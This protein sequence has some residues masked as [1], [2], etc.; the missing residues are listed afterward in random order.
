VPKADIDSGI[1]PTKNPGTWPGR[2]A[3]CSRLS[4]WRESAGSNAR[5]NMV[6]RQICRISGHEPT[7]MSRDY[8]IDNDHLLERMLIEADVRLIGLG[9]LSA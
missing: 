9:R 6:P 7:A 4:R 8:H 5:A 2:S 3:L 1:T